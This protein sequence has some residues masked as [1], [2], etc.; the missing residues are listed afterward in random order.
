MA[1]KA[2]KGKTAKL[3]HA[4]RL[5]MSGTERHYVSAREL[6]RAN[7]DVTDF[8]VLALQDD[9]KTW[10]ENSDAKVKP[11][12]FLE[13][14]INRAKEIET[15]IADGKW[16]ARAIVAHAFRYGGRLN[17]A[18]NLYAR[19]KREMGAFKKDGSD[20][21]RER[22]DVLADYVEFWAYL[23]YSAQAEDTFSL[24]PNKLQKGWRVWVQAFVQHQA[25]FTDIFPTVRPA[26]PIGEIAR[27]REAI[28]L[29]G[30]A[31]LKGGDEVDNLSPKEIAD[32]YLLELACWGGIYRR[33]TVDG[34]SDDKLEP[35]LKSI[36]KAKKEFINRK[37]AEVNLFWSWKKELRGQI[38]R[39]WVEGVDSPTNSAGKAATA[40]WRGVLADH[41]RLNLAAAG[42]GEDA[43]GGK[44]GFTPPDFADGETLKGDDPGDDD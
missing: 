18:R 32:T 40:E 10:I 41:Y 1:K 2:A 24:I 15:A 6:I 30:K 19:A 13:D 44:P 34:A 16:H 39:R 5:L 4:K 12:A 37:D 27:D 3:D 28:S 33:L 17:K 38:A 7:K 42:I 43:S 25:A 35:V 31:R 11:I 23:G 9:V 14:I 22:A 8:Q 20:A 21:D 36:K 26:V 29:L